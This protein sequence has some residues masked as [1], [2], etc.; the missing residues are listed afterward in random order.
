MRDEDKTKR[1]LIAELAEMRRRAAATTALEMELEQAR[2]L[3]RASEQKRRELVSAGQPIL[4]KCD[5]DGQLLQCTRGWYEYTGQ[6]RAE[7]AGI[8]WLAAVHPEDKEQILRQ[9][10]AA[11]DTGRYE[12]EYRLRRA[13]DGAYR[14]HEARAFAVKD[15]QGQVTAWLGTIIDIEAQKEAEESLRRS[16]VFKGE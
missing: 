11:A 12:A 3:L 10:F 2:K 13:A 9:M 1:Q 6:S 15:R 8:G 7:A 5:A 14:W 4:I 16:G